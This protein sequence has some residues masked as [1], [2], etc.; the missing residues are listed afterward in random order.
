M[1][2]DI[3]AKKS[4]RKKATTGV[5]CRYNRKDYYVT[6][7]ANHVVEIPKEGSATKFLES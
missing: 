1:K 7:C 5:F 4:C 3:C 2:R 6:L